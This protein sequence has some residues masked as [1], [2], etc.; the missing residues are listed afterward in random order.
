M[1]I[2]NIPATMRPL[3]GGQ[4]QVDVPGATLRE[5]IEALDSQYP[6]MKVRLLED[7]RLQPG[8]AVWV[9][10]DTPST[11]LRTRL[12]PDSEVYFAPAIAGGS[13]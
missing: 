1:A 13:R 2:V 5:V 12:E 8:L 4:T 6:G 3:A 7:D 11:G 10:G 9:D